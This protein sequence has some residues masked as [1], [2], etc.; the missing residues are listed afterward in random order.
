MCLQKWIAASEMKY[1]IWVSD[2]PLFSIVLNC[3]KGVLTTGFQWV[4]LR[5]SAHM[6]FVFL[7]N[8]V[9]SS[10]GRIFAKDL[11]FCEQ[12]LRKIKVNTIA[13][14]G[15]TWKKG[16]KSSPLLCNFLRQ[17]QFLNFKIWTSQEACCLSYHFFKYK[18]NFTKF[19]TDTKPV[20][21]NS[22]TLCV[23]IQVC[24]KLSVDNKLAECRPRSSDEPGNPG[25]PEGEESFFIPNIMKSPRAVEWTDPY[26]SFC[27][28]SLYFGSRTS[29]LCHLK[30][31]LGIK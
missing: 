27:L 7:Q 11:R 23:N 5:V 1:S 18:P 6:H 30:S 26:L 3:G 10:L 17:I 12:L 15:R 2:G 9:K 4:Y 29:S 8:F 16:S 21:A 13:E 22:L 20:S 25:K 14:E 28:N 31:P 19:C 24:I